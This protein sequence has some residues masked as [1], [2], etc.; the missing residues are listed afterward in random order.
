MRA[1]KVQARLCIG[2]NSTEPSLLE[3]A[4]RTTFPVLFSHSLIN[5]SS[6][7][8]G[9]TAHYY[10]LIWEFVNVSK[11]V[12]LANCCQ[13][14]LTL[15]Q[16]RLIDRC[17]TVVKFVTFGLSGRFSIIWIDQNFYEIISPGPN[18]TKIAINLLYCGT[19]DI[20]GNSFL[21]L[22][23]LSKIFFLLCLLNRRHSSKMQESLNWVFHFMRK[24]NP[25][26]TKR[27]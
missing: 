19:D 4:I 24:S 12:E 5:A 10:K 6:E 22:Y 1:A 7:C 27:D 8:S 3:N 2:I 20:K 11:N 21:W 26:S 9:K 23:K 14:P 13:K 18:G 15:A 17:L 25:T 16:A